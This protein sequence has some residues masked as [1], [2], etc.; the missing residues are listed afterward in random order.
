MTDGC[1]EDLALKNQN[2]NQ[3]NLFVLHLKDNG[4][5]CMHLVLGSG[6]R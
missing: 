1:L 5:A 2:Q 3:I 6:P 4:Y